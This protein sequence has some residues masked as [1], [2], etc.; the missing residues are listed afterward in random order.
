MCS[1]S[2]VEAHVVI[3]GSLSKGIVM[4]ALYFTRALLCN[5]VMFCIMWPC[6]TF[7]PQTILTVR[8][9]PNRNVLV[10]AYT[11]KTGNAFP[12]EEGLKLELKKA[13]I[14]VTIIGTILERDTF[15]GVA[16]RLPSLKS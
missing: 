10:M 16:K 5:L 1:V 9:F 13:P 14:R 11:C 15:Y 8:P 2:H 7:N 12:L 3:H 4:H 6:L